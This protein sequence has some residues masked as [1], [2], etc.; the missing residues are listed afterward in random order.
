MAVRSRC[1]L[2]PETLFHNQAIVTSMEDAHALWQKRSGTVFVEEESCL[3]FGPVIASPG[4]ACCVVET[5]RIDNP[6]LVPAEIV[7]DLKPN[8]KGPNDKNAS[9]LHFKSDIRFQLVF[10]SLKTHRPP[11]VTGI[12]ISVPLHFFRLKLYVNPN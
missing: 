12:L 2:Q 7:F 3:C 9:Q 6:Q 8:T 1:F 10:C 5:I 4:A 11:F